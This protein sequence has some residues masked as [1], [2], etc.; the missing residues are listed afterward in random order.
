MKPPAIFG[1]LC[2]PDATGMFS[3]SQ[4]ELLSDGYGKSRDALAACP[5][6]LSRSKA[7]GYS[8]L[9]HTVRSQ[10][11]AARATRG[12]FLYERTVCVIKGKNSVPFRVPLDAHMESSPPMSA[13]A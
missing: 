5:D 6:N 1:L 11:L 2:R 10:H 12:T 4:G 8:L 3:A 13:L 9:V 7:D